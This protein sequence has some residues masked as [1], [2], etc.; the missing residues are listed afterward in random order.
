[1]RPNRDTSHSFLTIRFAALTLLIE[2]VLSDV[3]EISVVA[4]LNI[5]TEHSLQSIKYAFVIQ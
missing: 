1:M 2:D 5:F 4:R 3:L